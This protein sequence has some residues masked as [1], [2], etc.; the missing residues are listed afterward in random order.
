MIQDPDTRADVHR[1]AVA[2]AGDHPGDRATRAAFLERAIEAIDRLAHDLDD[3]GLRAALAANTDAAVLSALGVALNG[4][5]VTATPVT[6][7]L[8]AEILETQRFALIVS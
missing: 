4:A 3:S 7:L 2:L 8:A 6:D 5:T 1:V